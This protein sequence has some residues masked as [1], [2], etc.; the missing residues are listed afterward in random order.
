MNDYLW[1]PVGVRL[2]NWFS[3][4]ETLEADSKEVR[5]AYSGS[6]CESEEPRGREL[7]Q[8]AILRIDEPEGREKNSDCF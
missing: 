2:V 1:D 6:S 3:S 8:G 7:H 5:R 4:L